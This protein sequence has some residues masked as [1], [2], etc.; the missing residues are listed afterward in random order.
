[1]A[2]SGSS[3]AS[4]H[5]SKV[6]KHLGHSTSNPTSWLKNG[7]LFIAVIFVIL[8]I[9]SGFN[10]YG[11]EKPWEKEVRFQLFKTGEDGKL[12][13]QGTFTTPRTVTHDWK[14][15]VWTDGMPIAFLLPGEKVQI[16]YCADNKPLHIT[17]RFEGP[18]TYTKPSKKCWKMCKN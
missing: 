5:T 4:G 1:M 7:I 15:Q 6:R 2:H 12:A 8:A 11:K 10:S 3:P 14:S 17:K 9:K 13:P 18:V 16:C